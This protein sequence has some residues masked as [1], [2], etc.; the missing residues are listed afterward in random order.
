ME[1]YIR[2]IEKMEKVIETETYGLTPT[3]EN[4]VSMKVS[5]LSMD[6]D[7]QNDEFQ[8]IHDYLTW[9]ARG[10]LVEFMKSCM[11]GEL[12]PEL[13]SQK[14]KIYTGEEMV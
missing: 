3:I 8:S 1:S 10:L 2:R 11:T 7:E 9:F 13:V 14:M 6:S 4:F 12:K 5:E